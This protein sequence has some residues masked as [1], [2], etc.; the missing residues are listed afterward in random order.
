MESEEAYGI[1]LFKS[2]ILSKV[3]LTQ[4]LIFVRGI[5]TDE[6][7]EEAIRLRNELVT[8]IGDTF[9]S[10][11]KVTLSSALVEFAIGGAMLAMI[12]D[13]MDSF[14]RSDVTPEGATIQ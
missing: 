13:A 7:M 6:E 4:Y 8:W 2:M 11:S 10:T 1:D 14:E 9:R 12:K 3:G 5:L